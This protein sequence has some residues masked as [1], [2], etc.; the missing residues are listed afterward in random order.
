VAAERGGYGAERYEKLD[1][2]IEVAKQ[3]GLLH[4]QTWQAIDATKSIDE[5]EEMIREASLKV[6]SKC[7]EGKVL[8]HLWESES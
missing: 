5:V 3:Y 2:Q 6:I 1:F 7:K 8:Q 4:D